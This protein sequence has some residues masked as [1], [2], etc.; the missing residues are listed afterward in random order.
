MQVFQE[1]RKPVFFRT[2]IEQVMK[3]IPLI[4]N[5]LNGGE[6]SSSPTKISYDFFVDES[7]TYSTKK[8]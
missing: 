5:V 4:R 6:D 2:V 7:L 1:K 8:I 3:K